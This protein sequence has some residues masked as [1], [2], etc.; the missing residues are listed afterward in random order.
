MLGGEARRG[1][2]RRRAASRESPSSTTTNAHAH[3]HAHN[4]GHGNDSVLNS[5]YYLSATESFVLTTTSS[6]MMT[7][8]FETVLDEVDDDLVVTVLQVVECRIS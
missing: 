1:E 8:L 2:E 5:T 4:H 3:G 6:L 7:V